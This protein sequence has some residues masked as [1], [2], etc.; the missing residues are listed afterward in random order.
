MGLLLVLCFLA[1]AA[2]SSWTRKRHGREDEE[3]IRQ[4]VLQARR[5]R[6]LREKLERAKQLRDEKR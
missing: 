5:A 6:D 1:G 4:L 3:R 2:F